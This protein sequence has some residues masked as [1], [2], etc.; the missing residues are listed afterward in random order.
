MS[1]QGNTSERGQSGKGVANGDEGVVEKKAAKRPAQYAK[2]DSRYWR[3]RVFKPVVVEN[4]S[5]REVRHFSVRMQWNGKRCCFP[6]NCGNI[7]VAALAAA[8]IFKSLQKNGWP[9]TLVKYSPGHQRP[10]KEVALTVGAYIEAAKA[11]SEASP[12]TFANYARC[13]RRIVAEIEGISDVGKDA[14]GKAL[15]KYDYRTG[16]RAA[17]AAKVD[18]VL[19]A[20]LHGKVQQWRIAF[21]KRAGSD[22]MKERSA[23]ISA[24]STIQQAMGLFSE[25]KILRHLGALKLPS[26]LPFDG[27]GRFE[28]Q[29]MRYSSKVDAGDLLRAGAAELAE[30]EREQWKVLLL[31]LAAGMRRKE[32]DLLLWSQVD[33]DRRV[34]RIEATPY[35][36]PKS[37]D[38]V[39]EISIDEELVALLRGYRAKA[40]EGAEF[41]IESAFAP[42]LGATYPVARA[43]K[44]FD[45]LYAWLRKKGVDG[46]RPL[47]TLRKEFGSMICQQ[48]GLYAASR[49][50]R[51]ADIQVTTMHYLDRKER[52]T[53]GLG[54]LLS[55]KNVTKHP[56][57]KRKA[58]A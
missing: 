58:R 42:K 51:H 50:L 31:A 1:T 3:S 11:V 53:L 38:S 10:E 22:P 9:E 30:A 17:W 54:A 57:G 36:A 20:G 14:K 41:V 29:S 43:K 13:F 16:G 52:V 26:P 25:R 8:N 18:A 23:K 44:V 12:L 4:G 37:A 28:R 55:P 40:G 2:T 35:F 45:G 49:A 6:L 24:N 48:A 34:I 56:G 21:V 5:R 46:N 39:G 33:F 7:E 47:H 32:I 19:V 15:S 27:V